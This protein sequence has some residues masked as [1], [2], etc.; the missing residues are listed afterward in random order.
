MDMCLMRF[1]HQSSPWLRPT[2]G[3]GGTS[4]LI[5]LNYDKFQWSIVR[6]L[7]GVMSKRDVIVLEQLE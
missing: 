4:G 7:S 6:T 3:Y 5:G 2:R 1:R